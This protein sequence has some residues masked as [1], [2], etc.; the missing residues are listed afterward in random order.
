MQFPGEG[1]SSEPWAGPRGADVSAPAAAST[2]IQLLLV[3]P[4]WRSEGLQLP[5][6]S[7]RQGWCDAGAEKA[8]G[9]QGAVRLVGFRVARGPSWAFRLP[10]AL[11]C[12]VFCSAPPPVLAEDLFPSYWS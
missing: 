11:Y 12:L 6:P 2:C 4:S 1:L 3:S 8:Q 10:T 9:W 7:W 5:E